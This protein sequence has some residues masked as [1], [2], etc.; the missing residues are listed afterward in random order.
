MDYTERLP[1]RLL[2]RP[3][4]M[5]NKGYFIL[6]KSIFV[7]EGD[8]VPFSG[9]CDNLTYNGTFVTQRTNFHDETFGYAGVDIPV[10]NF[11]T[12]LRVIDCAPDFCIS[13][14]SIKES[15]IHGSIY[16]ADYEL[17]KGRPAVLWYGK[18]LIELL[19]IIREWSFM[20]DEPFFIDH[21]MAH[22]SKLAMNRLNPPQWV[23]DE[24][25][26]L[27]DMHLARFLKG[28]PDHRSFVEDFPQMSDETKNWMIDKLEEFKPKST[29]DRLRELL[30]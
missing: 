14:V 28:D 2:F 17:D 24:I 6:L 29:N 15:H 20:V 10:Q 27:P 3:P 26:S 12:W 21:P 11:N 4:S 16:L 7:V 30:I 1:D 22:Y 8:N 18:T 19:K 23:L 13:F 25:D 9:R 5:N